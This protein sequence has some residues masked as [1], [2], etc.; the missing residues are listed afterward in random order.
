[1]IVFQG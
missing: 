1:M